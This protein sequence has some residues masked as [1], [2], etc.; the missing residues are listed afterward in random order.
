MY[1]LYVDE[2]DTTDKDVSDLTPRWY[3]ISG[4]RIVSSSYGKTQRV[5]ESFIGNKRLTNNFELK[6]EELYQGTGFWKGKEVPQ[7]VD[8]CNRVCKFINDSNFKIYSTL[9][10]VKD[11]NSIDSYKILLNDALSRVAKDVSGANLRG[12]QFILI[13]DQRKDIDYKIREQIK[14]N[15]T[16]IIKKYKKS[17]VFIDYGF[18]GDSKL[19]FGIQ[20]ADFTSYF[21]RKQQ[22]IQ[23]KDNL[24]RKAAHSLSIKAVDDI[25]ESIKERC[26]I[27]YLDKKNY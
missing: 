2:S 5:F 3:C 19:C 6:G 27:K 13:F 17:C 15:R 12:R 16:E 4:M 21:L 7:R 14:L 22:T 20:I 23:R 10:I 26:R 24:F 1:L 8:F 25:I 11:N 9:G 18:E